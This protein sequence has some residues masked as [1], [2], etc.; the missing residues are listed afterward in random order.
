VLR[1]KLKPVWGQN[2]GLPA[3]RS[4]ISLIAATRTASLAGRPPFLPLPFGRWPQEGTPKDPDKVL[5]AVKR[6]KQ[7]LE[8]TP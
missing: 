7:A 5:A 1:S 3:P 8:S 6:G 4:N 2:A